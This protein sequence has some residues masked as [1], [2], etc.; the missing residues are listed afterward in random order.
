[1]FYFNYVFCR[2]KPAARKI[3][4]A[5]RKKRFGSDMNNNEDIIDWEEKSGVDQLKVKTLIKLRSK[6]L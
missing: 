4:F 5:E 1:M 6:I 3:K 2:A